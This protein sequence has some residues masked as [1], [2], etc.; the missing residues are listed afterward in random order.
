MVRGNTRKT[1]GW[2]YCGV[3]ILSCW[4]LFLPKAIQEHN[5]ELQYLRCDGLSVGTFTDNYRKI[6]TYN[7][8]NSS[9]KCA[10][11]KC[12]PKITYERVIMDDVCGGTVSCSSRDTGLLCNEANLKS[13]DT[14]TFDFDNGTAP[15]VRGYMLGDRIV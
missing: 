3:Q 11:H 2:D 13:M 1:L 5:R 4:G 9:E 10:D 14:P 12:V 7:S 8:C 15:D 6:V